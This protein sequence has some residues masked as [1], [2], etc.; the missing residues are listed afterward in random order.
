MH[1]SL[2]TNLLVMIIVLSSCSCLPVHSF[3]NQ[4]LKIP[5]WK[6]KNVIL[7]GNI[8]EDINEANQLTGIGVVGIRF[9][10]QSG[11]PSYVQEV[12]PNS[13]AKKAGLNEKDLIF[14]I[15]GVRTD[16]LNSEGVYQLLSGKPGSKVKIFIT[17]GKS[18]FNLEITRTDLANLSPSTQNRYLSG[19]VTVPFSVKDLIP[20]Q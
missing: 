16:K 3:E 1:R 2:C 12:Y 15:N 7:R 4:K 6:E 13:P 9:I 11:Y 8:T 17:R 20:Y 5:A 14:A 18:M 10:H 19:P